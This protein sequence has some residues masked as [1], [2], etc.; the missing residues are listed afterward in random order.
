MR[1]DGTWEATREVATRTIAGTTIL[2]AVR[3]T[4]LLV[5]NE[6]ALAI[7]EHLTHSGTFT[8][9]SVLY[10]LRREYPEV[11]EQRISEDVSVF[12]GELARKDFIRRVNGAHAPAHPSINGEVL[13]EVTKHSRFS[14]RINTQAATLNI[15]ISGCIELTQRCP[16]RCAHCY[17][18]GRPTDQKNRP[19]TEQILFVLNQMKEAGSLWLLITGGE[20]LLHRDFCQIYRHAKELGMIP[21]VFTS[22]TMITDRV[23]E[24]FKRYPPLLIEA[25]L[26]G[27]SAQTFDAVTGIQGSFQKFLRGVALLRENK[28]PFNL[29][30][31]VM[32]QNLA[33]AKLTREF[34]LSLGAA[35]FRY[36]SMIQGD[37]FE[38]GKAQNLRITVE[39]ALELDQTE[40]YHQLWKRIYRT[41]LKER[42]SGKGKETILFPCRAGKSSFAVSADL[43]LLPC[44]LMR[45][46]S[47]DLLTKPFSSAWKKLNRHTTTIQM[48]MDNACRTCQTTSCSQC[49]AWGYLEHGDPNMKSGFACALEH[50][51]E[52]LF[53]T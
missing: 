20:P 1:F 19:S 3:G 37:F 35:N 26:H 9:N 30:M 11:Q 47:Y 14:E 43:Q 21:T 24:V 32:Q 8:A 28:I 48:G 2:L 10:A 15:P 6:T 44:I 49:P 39:E 45:T 31:V 16:L 36:D 17:I 13:K 22:A 52:K 41:A 27:A 34:A 25:T 23:V 5:L 12:L 42:S 40:S 18:D 46:P 7:W 33:E 4:T 51:R 38:S 29:K 50:G 53:L